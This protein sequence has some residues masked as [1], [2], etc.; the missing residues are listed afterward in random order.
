MDSWPA[1]LSRII[2]SRGDRGEDLLETIEKIALRNGVLNGFVISVI[3]TLENCKIHRVT[4][5]SLRPEEEYV[6][7]DGPLEINSVS[8]IIANGKLHA[9]I[10]V[11]DRNGTY[12]GHLEPGSK[13]LYLAEIVIAES[14]GI[15]LDRI[16]DEKTGLR[17]LKAV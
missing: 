7:I 1:G 13:I 8:G 17:L 5:K 14:S 4:S 16:L 12:G 11:S 10:S 3:G 9:H 6:D 15:K 2:V